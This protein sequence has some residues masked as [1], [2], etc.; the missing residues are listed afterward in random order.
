MT[1]DLSA[2]ISA[3]MSRISSRA[4][5]CSMVAS[6]LRSIES[7]SALKIADLVWKYSLSRAHRLG[8]ADVDDLVVRAARLPADRRR[9]GDLGARAAARGA[10]GA[11]DAAPRADA[12]SIAAEGCTLAKHVG[13]LAHV[14]PASLEERGQLEAR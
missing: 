10:A 2:M 12:R 1:I 5:S 3:T 6:W 14:R 8:A 13:P 7:I 11:A 9:G 4:A